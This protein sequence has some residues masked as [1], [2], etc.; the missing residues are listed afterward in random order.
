M[1]MP[2]Y[3]AARAGD[4]GPGRLRPEGHRPGSQP[5]RR[6]R[7]QGIV[8]VRREPVDHAAQ[9]VGDLRPHRLR[10]RRPL[11]RVRP[12]AH[13]RRPPRR[14]QGLLVQPRGRRRPEP[15][16][17]VRP[18]PRPDLH[19]RDE[20]DGGRDPRGR[21]RR[22]RRPTTSC[23]TSSTTAPSSTSRAPPCSAATPRPS[24]SACAA[25]RASTIPTS[26]PPSPPRPSALAGPDRTLG[27]AELEVAV[28]ARSGERR[29]FRRLEDDE[30]SGSWAALP[31]QPER[32]RPSAFAPTRADR[33]PF[34]GDRC[35]P[36]L[37][38]RR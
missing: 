1:S 33:H 37:S 23:S 10:R 38:A 36:L 34:A 27:A 17:P 3:V 11:Q 7:R 32:H 26:A 29:C 9:G 31:R 4:E 19:P 16:Q 22:R 6:R 24:P 5:R 12:A 18:D 28:L 14:P 21:G 13:R 2:F 20:A 8:I 15:R 35:P 30:V 25:A